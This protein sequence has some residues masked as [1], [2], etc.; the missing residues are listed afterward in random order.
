MSWG[1]FYNAFASFV[2]PHTVQ[3]DNGK[4]SIEKVQRTDVA[5]R[6]RGRAKKWPW[7]VTAKYFLIACGGRPSYGDYPGAKAP[8][9][10]AEVSQPNTDRISCYPKG[11]T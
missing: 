10:C 4:G 3:L 11:S 7:E 2:D 5:A 1:R 9:G 8:S 6:Q